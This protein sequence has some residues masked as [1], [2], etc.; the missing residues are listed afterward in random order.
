MA[1]KVDLT[2]Q[3]IEEASR[4]HKSL[5]FAELMQYLEVLCYHELMATAPEAT[6]DREAIYHKVQAL[7]DIQATLRNIAQEAEKGEGNA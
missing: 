1:V 7:N 2:R 6:Q 5:A 4:L 3:T